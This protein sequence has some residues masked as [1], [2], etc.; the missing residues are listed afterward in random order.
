[1]SAQVLGRRTQRHVLGP[2]DNAT[3][4]THKYVPC[5]FDGFWF[6]PQPFLQTYRDACTT[7]LHICARSKHYQRPSCSLS[8]FPRSWSSLRCPA[9]VSAH[10]HVYQSDDLRPLQMPR[11]PPPQPLT[12]KSHTSFRRVWTPLKPLLR[13]SLARTAADTRP[14]RWVSRSP[15]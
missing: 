10:N 5:V 4:Q 9:P 7:G 11:P 13:P 12:P 15:L 14:G 6:H 8:S 1:M 3:L 2:E